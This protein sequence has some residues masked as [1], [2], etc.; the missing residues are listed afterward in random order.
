MYIDQGGFYWDITPTR[1]TPAGAI[2]FGSTN[3]SSSITVTHVS[4]GCANGDFVT[5]SSATTLGGNITAA[6]LNQEYQVTVVSDNTYTITARTAGTSI[7]DITDNGV[8]NPTPVLADGSDTGSGGASVAA[9]YQIN[10][11]LGVVVPGTGW[12]IEHCLI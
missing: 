7:A 5:F 6:V 9:T 11:G 12:S 10:V 1:A 8:L 3:G 4:H 2:T